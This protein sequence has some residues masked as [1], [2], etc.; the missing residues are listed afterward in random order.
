[1]SMLL[2]VDAGN[3]RVKWA[4]AAPSHGSCHAALGAWI[5][6][7][8]VARDAL[9]QLAEAWRGRPVSR[10]L[11]SNVAGDAMRGALDQ[12]LLR[13]F[14]ARALVVEWFRS[15]PEAAGVRNHYRHPQQLG[16]DRFA[17]AIG[18]HA[19][20]PDEA[21]VVVT[22]GTA[23]TVDAVTPDGG[24]L[25]GMILPGL[26]LMASSLAANTAQLPRVGDRIEIV[27]PFADNTIDAIVSGCVAAQTGAIERALAAL[28]REHGR[29]RCLLS[30][31]AGAMLAPF[32]SQPATLVENLVLI[33]LQTVLMEQ[34]ASC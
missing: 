2:L 30:G 21:L 16:S 13:A 33:G 3:T 26:G 11:L 23:T 31:G 20:Y 7:G 17:S 6:A 9:P 27:T 12:Q 18:A 8:A 34:R 5:A 28:G 4:L 14:G 22:C 24:F 1:M 29:V 15:A 32:L 10:V 19:L 25:G